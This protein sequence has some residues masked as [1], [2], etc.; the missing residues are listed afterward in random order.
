[1]NLFQ[2]VIGHESIIDHMTTAYRFGKVSHAYILE[3]EEGMGKKM[4]TNCFVKLLQC[5]N[6]EGDNPCNVCPS[7][8]QIDTGNH[9]DV[10]YVK[11]T[12]KSGYGVNDVRDQMVNDVN[13]KP[14][15]SKYKIY[16]VDEADTMT[17]QAQNSILKTIEEPPEYGMFFL[18]ANNSQKFLQTILS[19]A[20]KMSLKPIDLS[21]IERYLRA[22]K[23]VNGDRAKVIASF[24]RGNIGKALQ[25]IESETFNAQR[26][27][28]VKC[29][30][31]FINRGEYDIMEAVNLFSEYKEHYL[32]V[33]DI[34]VSLVRDI[35]YYKETSSSG[36]LIH[37]DMEY[38]I[39]ELSEKASPAKL[40]RLVKNSHEFLNWQRLNVNFGLS[41]FTMFTDL[42][43]RK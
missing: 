40:V 10:V 33:L 28:M 1:M 36:E 7:C 15:R 26:N 27:D 9:P 21:R 3:G 32:E 19:R 6:P 41:V 20:V 24:S 16:I 38:R 43:D 34:L 25:L 13:V 42:E 8:V 4:L 11:P 39:I 14:Y 31:V 17:V 18:L 2:D 30:D 12:K 23:Q 22:E 35:L 5:E 37:K 29:L